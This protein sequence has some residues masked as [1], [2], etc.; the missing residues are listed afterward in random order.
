MVKKKI[1]NCNINIRIFGTGNINIQGG[2][3]RAICQRAYNEIRAI[4][5]E[6]KY[7]FLYLPDNPPLLSFEDILSPLS[8]K[9]D[10]NLNELSA[11]QELN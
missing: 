6:N 10:E 7:K 1:E 4:L 8:S 5:E 9:F 3:S 11:N 2:N